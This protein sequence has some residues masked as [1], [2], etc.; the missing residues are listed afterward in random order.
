MSV[1][2][3]S[4]SVAEYA[5][6][7]RTLAAEVGWNNEAL[8]AA[9]SHGLSDAL[10][11]EVAAKDLPVELEALIS[12]L[13]LID[14]RLR[15]RPSFKESLRRPPNSLAPTF[16]VPPV[17]PSP[18]TPPG[19]DLSGGEPMQLGFARLSEGE[20]ALRRREGR[21]MYCG[22]GGHFRLACPNRPGNA[23]T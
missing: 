19:V 23:R 20:R 3:G 12:F 17:P 10:K 1:R 21:C 15:E 4:R 11:D 13:I 9:F 2:Q 16:A 14:T 8:V 5:I 7:F 18:P 6:E 22:L